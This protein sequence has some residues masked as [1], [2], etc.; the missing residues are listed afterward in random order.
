MNKQVVMLSIQRMTGWWT[1]IKSVEFLRRRKWSLCLLA[2]VFVATFLRVLLLPHHEIIEGDGVHYAAHARM[3][4]EQGNWAGAASDYWSNLWPTAIAFF[5]RVAFW[6]DVELAGRFA[7]LTFGVLTVLFTYGFA[8]EAFGREHALI[9][10]GLV[11]VHPYLVRFSTLLYVESFFTCIVACTLWAGLL[12][13]QSPL[14]ITGWVMFAIPVAFGLWTR[15]ESLWLALPL[16]LIAGLKG[17]R[18]LRRS[19]VVAGV[20]AFLGIVLAALLV[21]AILIQYYHST[22]QFGFNQK[23]AINLILGESYYDT[24]ARERRVSHLLVDPSATETLLLQAN[25]LSLIWQLRAQI[26]KRFTVNLV[27]I[28][29]SVYNVILGGEGPLLRTLLLASLL[30]LGLREGGRKELRGG[31]FALASVAAVYTAPLSL[32][33][34]H[35]RLLVPLLP[36]AA[37]FVSL[38]T[39]SAI[40]LSDILLGNRSR[41]AKALN[42]GLVVLA[43]VSVGLSPYYSGKRLI[44]EADPVVQR[45]AGLWLRDHVSQDVRVLTNDPHIPFYFYDTDPYA[46]SVQRIPWQQYEVLLEYMWR[47]R[48]DIVA[49]P[50]W[51]LLYGNYPFKELVLAKENPEGIERLGVIGVN[52]PERVWIYRVLKTQMPEEFQR[53]GVLQFKGAVKFRV[54]EFQDGMWTGNFINGA[55]AKLTDPSGSTVYA[56]VASA[57]NYKDEPGWVDFSHVAPGEYSV[58]VYK[59]GMQGAWKQTTCEGAGVTHGVTIQNALTEGNVAVQQKVFI[60]DETVW[61]KD[62]GLE[63]I[64]PP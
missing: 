59:R 42:Y 63:A 9:S 46:Q 10:A 48:I 19:K 18:R 51:V 61:C 6:D 21:R 64:P 37:V 7:S 31:A 24:E 33:F 22:W 62:V 25:P 41:L 58:L 45:D 12:L 57:T 17:S 3:I 56:T 35:D 23:A 39:C 13:L 38:G 28:G 53:V 54:R 44:Y 29:K 11:A 43:I 47:E 16:V 2:L 34:V 4:A 49:F 52:P 36:I 20:V 1:L 32:V 27:H 30:I 15:P 55:T 14:R 26:L 50:E 60:S 40:R 5:E 8:R